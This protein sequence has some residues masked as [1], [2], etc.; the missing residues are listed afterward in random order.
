VQAVYCDDQNYLWIVDPAAP[1]METVI[2]DGPKLV[3]INPQTNAI[4]KTFSL[5]SITS[6]TSY[7]NDVRI[8]TKRG[9]AYMTRFIG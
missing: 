4:E 7:I 3:K 6:D 2:P 1:M 8:D 5:D 9:F